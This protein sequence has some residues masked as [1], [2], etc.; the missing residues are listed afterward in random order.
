MHHGANPLN[1]RGDSLRIANI[2][3][4]IPQVEHHHFVAL[5]NQLLVDM[6][7][8]EPSTPGQ[9]NAHHA[10]TASAAAVPSRVWRQV[11]SASAF[12]SWTMTSLSNC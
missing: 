10:P 2:A 6:L 11:Q 7:P 8:D 1:R 5:G 4:T 3:T 9:Q 12:G